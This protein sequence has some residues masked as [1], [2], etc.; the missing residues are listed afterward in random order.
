MR[1][2]ETMHYIMTPLLYRP[3]SPAKIENAVSDRS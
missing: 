2:M 3:A 1:E